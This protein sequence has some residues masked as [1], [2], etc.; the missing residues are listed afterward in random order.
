[1]AREASAP[2]G[3]VLSLAWRFFRGRGNRLLDG[4]ARAALI[5]TTLGVTAMVIAM[6]LMSGYRED[7]RRKLVRGNAAVIAYPLFGS[8]VAWN[9]ERQKEIQI[10][11]S[12]RRSRSMPGSIPIQWVS[13]RPIR[14]HMLPT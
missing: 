5:G 13:G 3:L 1:M 14:S 10:A 11:V 6:A 9:P 8:Q 7:L 4:T 12:R 2:T